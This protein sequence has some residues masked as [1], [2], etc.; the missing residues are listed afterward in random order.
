[1]SYDQRHRYPGVFH[2]DGGQDAW[3][4]PVPPPRM[5]PSWSFPAAQ[6]MVYHRRKSKGCMGISHNV[7]IVLLLLFLLVFAFMGIGSY[8]IHK[9]Q[10]DLRSMHEV[11]TLQIAVVW[12]EKPEW[13]EVKDDVRPAAHVLGRVDSSWR[14][15]TLRWEPKAGRAFTEGGVVY[16]A[17][18]GALRVNHTGL[19]HIYS[20][21][22]LLV[23]QCSMTHAFVHT[24]FVRRPRHVL[25][26]TL[27]EGQRK[28][29]CGDQTRSTWTIDSYLAG[30]LKLEKEDRVFVNV[31]HPLDLS[32]NHYANF[33]GL[34]KI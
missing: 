23:K 34:Y 13:I 7:A 18:D 1:M 14:Q 19:Y 22:E 30:S 9:L 2:V 26:L 15:K 5:V 27:M 31:S 4:P 12:L 10:G 32:H 25:P 28:E 29:T 8:Q 20:R 24:V 6:E 21:V 33:F 11:R 17:E 16:Q 3:R